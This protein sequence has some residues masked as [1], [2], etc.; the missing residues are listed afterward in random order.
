M[1]GR[2]ARSV[3][4]V[5][6]AV[7]LTAALVLATAAPA[8][9]AATWTKPAD[10]QVFASG[11]TVDLSVS[12]SQNLTTGTDLH[13]SGPGFADTVVASAPAGGA[14]TL[15]YA[16]ATSGRRNGSWTASLSGGNSGTRT[17]FLNFAPAAPSGLSAQGTGARDV[18]FSWTKGSEADLRGYTLTADDGTVLD[19][20]IP[21]SA[22]SGSA[23]SYALYYPS[24]NP[25][26]HGYRLLARRAGGG[27]S[28]CGSEVTSAPATTSATLTAPAPTPSPT[29]SPSASPDPAPTEGSTTGGSTTGGSSGTG[30][31]TTGGG[32]STTGGSTTGGSTTGGS[33]TGGSST[34]GSTTGGSSTG[35]RTS[36][37]GGF[38]AGPQPT[39]PSLADQVLASRQKFALKFN[40]FSPVLGIPKLPPLPALEIPTIGGAEGPLPTGTYNPT[41]PYTPTT[42]TEKVQAAKGGFTH[43]IAQLQSLDTTRLAKSLAGAL[44]LLLLGAHIR[45]FIGSHVSDS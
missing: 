3:A 8:S 41:L 20:A 25:G 37:S 28:G 10:G 24:D 35:G 39:L 14:R 26:T 31:S 44:I 4:A 1:P 27:C 6:G 38:V 40:A 17:F 36:T 32:S 16:L 34:G 13:L 23:C 2:P 21:L 5:L 30:G 9:A 12:V 18:T 42:T 45:R 43:P 29:P 22:C 33:T 11:S 15:S 7:P 19:G